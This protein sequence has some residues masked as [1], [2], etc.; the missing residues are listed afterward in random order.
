MT[1]PVQL[2]SAKAPMTSVA[3]LKGKKIRTTGGWTD[4][5]KA[6][7]AVP[8]KIG[9]GELYGALD[10]GTIDATV[11]YT[12]FV[13]SYKHFEVAN[14]LTEA[15]MGQLLGYGGG[16]N[17]KLF[18]KMPKNIQDILVKTS[19]EYMDVYAR[20]YIN[21]SIQ[22]KADMTAG[23]DGKKVQFHMLSASE[24]AIW[25][26]AA[27]AFTVKW[28]AKMEKKG[29]DTKKIITAFETTRAKYRK[30]LKDQGYPWDKTN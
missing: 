28:I 9:F 27:E 2:L 3:E 17:L 23:I 20:N 19:D 7:G 15:N 21:D 11:N 30:Q 25:E 10:N 1:G 24:R 13:K 29:V 5:F 4:L 22:A 8:V 16:I 14:H 18:N 12:P 26:A 6:L